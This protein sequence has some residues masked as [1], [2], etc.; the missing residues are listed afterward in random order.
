MSFSKLILPKQW[1]SVK[2]GEI[3]REAHLISPD[4]LQIALLEQSLYPEKRLGEIL[5]DQG[6]IQQ[7]TADFFAEKW[8]YLVTEANYQPKKRLGEYL[9]EAGLVSP[10][11]VEEI[12]R[13]QQHNR[14]WQRFGAIV[15]F[16]GWVSVST[17]DFF[18]VHLF[19]EYA[20]DSAFTKPKD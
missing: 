15:A 6:R 16:K 8:P 13:E 10:Q 19:P 9:L 14:L 12:L 17:V 20:A 1:N 18:L 5:S 2:L 11:Q 4:Q 7:Q 3:L